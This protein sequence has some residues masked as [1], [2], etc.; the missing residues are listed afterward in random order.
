MTLGLDPRGFNAAQRTAVQQLRGFQQQANTTANQ[1]QAGAGNRLQ[2]FWQSLGKPI[3]QAQANLTQL[4]GQSNRVGTQIAAGIN[5][6]T[7]SISRMTT[8]LLTAYGVIKTVQGAVRTL[9][10][11][12]SSGAETGRRA[13]YAGTSVSW[14]SRIALGAN[15]AE[16]V[17]KEQTEQ[18]LVE[19]RQF[20]ERLHQ[21]IRDPN[22]EAFYARAGVLDIAANKDMDPEQQQ[23]EMLRRLAAHYRTLSL[24]EAVTQG[25]QIGFNP[26]FTT[27]L[28]KH[29]PQGLEGLGAPY[30]VTERQAEQFR[31]LQSAID[32]FT[33]SWDAFI[34]KMVEDHPELEQGV[35]SLS[36]FLTSLKDSP[37]QLKA[38]ETGL[39]AI[40]GLI[41]I[42]L[43]A[44]IATFVATTVAQSAIFAKT[45]LGL[46]IMAA[47]GLRSMVAV[48]TPAQAEAHKK[49]PTS[50]LD[51]RRWLGIGP[52]NKEET[53]DRSLWE[54]WAPKSLGGRERTAGPGAAVP[55]AARGGGR[56]SVNL[57]SAT[58]GNE[59]FLRSIIKQAGGND[60]AVAG[61]LSNFDYESGGLNPEAKSWISGATGFAQWLGPRLRRLREIGDPKTREAQGKLLHEELTGAYKPVLDQ[62][63]RAKTPEESALIGLKG[64]EGVNERNSLRAGAPWDKMVRTHT[65]KAADYYRRSVDSTGQVPTP[66]SG[67]ELPVPGLHRRLPPGTKF[68]S[69]GDAYSP[70]LDTMD[71]A[72]KARVEQSMRAIRDSMK[73]GGKPWVTPQP[74]ALGASIINGMDLVRSSKAAERAPGGAALSTTTNHDIDIGDIHVHTPATDAAGIA[75]DMRGEIGRTLDVTNANTG[76]DW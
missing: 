43:V 61:L 15:I 4:G 51:P 69:G 31:K 10:D 24:P 26:A 16:H 17:P 63:N 59:T 68:N 58:A 47:M 25:Q 5:Q 39:I 28:R 33:A 37:G 3:G 21:G 44:A 66:L 11:A 45:P 57:P 55:G 40:I 32:T 38:I 48:P 13:G 75:R 53:D 49:D 74:G 64:F 6:G 71:A 70:D 73:P 18:S 29:G 34:N 67:A 30:A 36:T 65:A 35:K 72:T 14:M 50:F 76:L 56:S 60:M 1:V 27:A 46:L 42:R 12:I 9:N 23:R 52:Y 41:G 8:G 22:R 7:D 20:T 2:R 54:R 62:M 19:M